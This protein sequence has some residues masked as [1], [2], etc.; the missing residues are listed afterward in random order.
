MAI[1]LV[2]PYNLQNAMAA[3]AVGLALDFEPQEIQQALAGVQGVPGVCS[4]VPGPA[5][6]P[7]V[8]VDYAH[9]DQA[10]ASVLA[11]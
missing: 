11:A 8:L 3:T 2:G 1:P 9:S 7:T 10:L 5:G 4:G 6:A